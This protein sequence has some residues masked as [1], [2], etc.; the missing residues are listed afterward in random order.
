[1]SGTLVAGCDSSQRAAHKA[2]QQGLT[3]KEQG[4]IKEAAQQFSLA[5]DR[6]PH[7]AEA[8]FELG[9]MFC[10]LQD[11]RQAVKHLLRAT[12][13]EEV[14]AKSYAFLGY[15]YERLERVALAQ[16]AYK[17]AILKAPPV[18]I[19]TYAWPIFLK[20]REIAR[21]AATLL[22]QVLGVRD[23]DIENAAYLKERP[24]TATVGSICRAGALYI[25]GM[26]RL[27]ADWRISTRLLVG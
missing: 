3:L 4:K 24:I 6:D 11:Y 26:V 1:V 8:V 25:F 5:L 7:Y 22:E 10:A 20:T 14:S 2:Y 15:A 21:E 27:P 9:I 16:N 23:P 18:L 17:Q 12:E 13:Y 19:F